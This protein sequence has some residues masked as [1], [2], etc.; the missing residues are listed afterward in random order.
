MTPLC[1]EWK[2]SLPSWASAFRECQFGLRKQSLQPAS[3]PCPVSLRGIDG[4]KTGL[5]Q[6]FE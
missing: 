4:A 6:D 5:L 1:S 2:V 3:P